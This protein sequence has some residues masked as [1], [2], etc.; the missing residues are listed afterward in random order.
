MEFVLSQTFSED[1]QHWKLSGRLCLKCPN[2]KAKFVSPQIPY[3]SCR[4]FFTNSFLDQ[5][6]PFFFHSDQFAKLWPKSQYEDTEDDELDLIDWFWLIWL[7][8]TDWFDF[9]FRS[10]CT[11]LAKITIWGHGGRWVGWG[12]KKTK[13][14]WC[15][16]QRD[17][18][19]ICYYCCNT[20]FACSGCPGYGQFCGTRV[21]L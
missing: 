1:N 9:F 21:R 19:K 14:N 18:G 3:F 12:A 5:N 16:N 15:C 7:I 2:A 13:S 6:V 10:I 11:T 4:E 17:H 8:L 20:T